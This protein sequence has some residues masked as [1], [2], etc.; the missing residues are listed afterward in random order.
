MTFEELQAVNKE[1]RTTNIKGKEYAEVNQRILGFRKLH[2]NGCITTEIIYLEN[3]ICVIKAT[4]MDADGHILGTGHA[5]E[6][7]GSTF[8]NKT[9]YIENAETSCIGRALGMCGIGIDNAVASYEE[10][11]NAIAN[12]ENSKD[13]MKELQ[14]LV[15]ELA[16]V[17][18]DV[19][20]DETIHS[21]VLEKAKV[22]NLDAAVLSDV[23]AEAK[24]VIEVYKKLLDAKKKKDKENEVNSTN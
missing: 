17:N 21:Y 10:V 15:R 14:W 5:Y 9:S 20:D 3:G 24:R 8:I 1:L 22:Q 13:L 6:K 7:E 4:V 18:V 2:P 16:K 23:P 19:R 12:Q 11:S